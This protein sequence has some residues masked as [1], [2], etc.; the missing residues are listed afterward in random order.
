[1][2]DGGAAGRS[3]AGGATTGRFSA[4]EGAARFCAPGPP[5][6]DLLVSTTTVLER[7]W[8]KLCFT[9]PAL[10]EPGRGFSVRG[11]LPPRPFSLSSLMRS[12]NQPAKPE[13]WA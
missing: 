7:P 10:T 4:A 3:A 9:T 13:G 11:G 1:M 8:L 6:R 5:T 12:F 2:D